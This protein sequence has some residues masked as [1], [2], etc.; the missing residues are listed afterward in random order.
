MLN[1]VHYQSEVVLII[2]NIQYFLCGSIWQSCTI[3]GDVP[4]APATHR[5]QDSEFCKT[6]DSQNSERFINYWSYV[7]AVFF[8]LRAT[9]SCQCGWKSTNERDTVQEV[10]GYN[11]CMMVAEQTSQPENLP[12]TAWIPINTAVHSHRHWHVTNDCLW[13]KCLQANL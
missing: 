7:T 12:W 13:K 3:L 11:A 2:Y 6:C 8:L 4:Y 10:W 1:V 9:V 5:L